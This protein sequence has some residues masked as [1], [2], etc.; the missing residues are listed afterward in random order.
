MSDASREAGDL[1]LSDQLA[2]RALNDRFGYLLDH[3]R[4][5]EFVALFTPDV[6]YSNGAR[7]L[8]G[9]EEMLAF[10]RRRAESGRVSRHFYSGLQITFLGEDKASAVSLWT[11][12]AGEG[13]LPIA[14]ATPFNVADVEDTYSRSPDGQWLIAAR[15]I[16]PVFLSKTVPQLPTKDEWVRDGK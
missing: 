10:F 15:R 3:G 12:F 1:R 2:I 16:T 13:P 5:E 14:P 6:V 8:N 11:T 4:V 9:R 7:I